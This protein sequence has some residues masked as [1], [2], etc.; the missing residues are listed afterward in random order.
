[1]TSYI[2][3]STKEYPK[4]EGDIRLDHPEIGEQFECPP[5]YALVSE[6]PEPLFDCKTQ[7]CKELYPELVDG[8][9]IRRYEIINLT[10]QE[11]EFNEKVA[12]FYKNKPNLP[13]TEFDPNDPS[14]YNVVTDK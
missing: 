13:I 8:R 5:T 1:M 4:H 7:T 9:W 6:E 12:L 14:T 2:K 11:I 3:I 10:A